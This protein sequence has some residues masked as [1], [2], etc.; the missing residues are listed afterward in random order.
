MV[1]NFFNSNTIEQILNKIEESKQAYNILYKHVN[2]LK[3][4]G[5][6]DYIIMG[7]AIILFNQVGLVIKNEFFSTTKE[8]LPIDYK[9]LA[10]KLELWYVEYKKSWRKEAKESELL[11]SEISSLLM[12]IF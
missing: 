11:E 4:D 10:A 3:H 5:L 7:E 1:V 2:T 12:L 8:K 9:E 6:S